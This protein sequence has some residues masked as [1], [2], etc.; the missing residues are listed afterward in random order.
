MLRYNHRR[1]TNHKQKGL[2]TMKEIISMTK[3]INF[4][5]I[6]YYVEYADNSKD[7]IEYKTNCFG[8]LET[9]VNENI[10]NFEKNNQIRVTDWTSYYGR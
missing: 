8:E 4:Y 9:P 5:Y 7:R 1:N 2:D 10:K 3:E 6:A